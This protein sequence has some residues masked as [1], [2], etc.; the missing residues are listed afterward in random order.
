MI[1]RRY[2]NPF[3][4]GKKIP[5]ELFCDRNEETRTLIKQIRNGR[6]VALVSPRRLGK[7]GLIHHCFA[8]EE[9]VDN[10]YTFYIDLYAT[11]SLKELVALLGNEIYRSLKS[12][13]SKFVEKFF[14]MV[15]S[16]RL[17]FSID[18]MTGN[19]TIDLGIGEI[20]VPETT[21]FEI[22]QYLE[23][24]DKPCLVAI[25][26]FQQIGAYSEKNVEALL[27]T[28][29][30]RCSTTS[31]IFSGSK[32][33]VMSNMFNSPSKPFYQSAI[34]MGLTT[35]PLSTYEAF[36]IRLFKAYDK[37]IDS[38]VV[39]MVYDCFEGYT[40][41]VQ[42]MMNELFSITDKGGRC[43]ADMISSAE[44][45]ILSLQEASYESTM[46]MLSVKQKQVLHAIATEGYARTVTS[47]AFIKKHHLVSPSSLQTA[48][49]ALIDKNI[50][51]LTDKGYRIEDFFFARWLHSTL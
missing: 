51:V 26:E 13:Q 15:Q 22:F 40:W 3:I 34:T 36:A 10:Y 11:S 7:S 46:H 16:L 1:S 21:L 33:H 47:G 48:L 6:N 28:Y 39:Q 12:R 4:L 30:Q 18:S 25:D 8:Q 27:R 19:P 37:E 35:I 44:R 2:T 17:G 49:T 9:I 38:E 31:F 42:M 14:A 50:V 32:R 23:A 45:N 20:Q 29:I 43:T 41:F 24:A 5:E